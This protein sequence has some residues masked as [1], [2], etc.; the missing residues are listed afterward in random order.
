MFGEI[1]HLA[2]MPKEYERH[3]LNLREI[4]SL[5]VRGVWRFSKH[6]HQSE[7]VHESRK[8]QPPVG[9]VRIKHTQ[10]PILQ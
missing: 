10:P 8:R 6:S 4:R 2:T 9:A 3:I 1:I 5:F 7:K